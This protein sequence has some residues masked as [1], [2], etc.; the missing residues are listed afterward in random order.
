LRSRRILIPRRR[1]VHTLL[2]FAGVRSTKS[3]R[4]SGLRMHSKA[5]RLTGKHPASK[6][7]GP[8][9][10]STLPVLND[11]LSRKCAKAPRKQVVKYRGYLSAPLRL[12][13]K[14]F[15]CPRTSGAAFLRP[16]SL[17]TTA[18]AIIEWSSAPAVAKT[19]KYGGNSETSD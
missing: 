9:R 8:L 7:F 14:V 2:R 15:P 3:L 10:T 4:Q 18:R 19:R 13:G 1:Q 17:R 16:N 12:C 6:M 11:E 5:K